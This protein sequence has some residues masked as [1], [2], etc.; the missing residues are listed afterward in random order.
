MT[1]LQI[2]FADLILTGELP[3]YKCYTK[4]GYKAATDKVAGI[5]AANLI[6][7]HRVAAYIAAKR[8]KTAKRH[9]NLADRVI[10]EVKKLAFSNMGDYAEWDGGAVDLRNSADLTEDQKA[11]VAEVSQTVTKDGGSIKFKLHDKNA[12][13]DKLCKK[14]G[15]YTEAAP[16]VV[17]F[18]PI[19][20]SIRQ[21]YEEWAETIKEQR[22]PK[23]LTTG[24]NGGNGGDGNS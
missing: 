21:T 14:L 11:C 17:I 24:G 7:S 8:E 3:D 16:S 23:L 6:V 9:E 19:Q 13:L 22:A 2:A 5:N 10:E 18:A 12:A 15:I 1:T 20:V 4:A